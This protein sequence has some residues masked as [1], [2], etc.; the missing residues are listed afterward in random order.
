MYDEKCYFASFST[1]V[2][3][4]P[5]TWNDARGVCKNIGATYDLVKIETK[6]KNDFLLSYEW[7]G[8]YTE[9]AA[10]SFQMWIGL[11]KTGWTDGSAFFRRFQGQVNLPL[12]MAKC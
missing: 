4:P 2:A 1:P 11:D 12:V 9:Q 10:P 3:T 8:A 5:M 7:G 6:A